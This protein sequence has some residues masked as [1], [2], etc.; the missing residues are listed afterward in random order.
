VVANVANAPPEEPAA[1]AHGFLSHADDLKLEV[2]GIFALLTYSGIRDWKWGTAYWR[3]NPEGWFGMDT[4]S[5][6]KDKL[7]HAYS[8]YVMTELF[9]LRL[10]NKYGKAAPVTVYP[11]IFSWILMLYVEFFDGFSVDHG[12]SYEDLVMDTVGVSASFFR[13]TFPSVGRVVDYRLEYFPSETM[14]GFHPM[15]DY[16]GQKFL[17]AFRPGGLDFLH[18]TPARFIELYV[19]Y[20]TRGFKNPA[21]NHPKLQRLYVGIGMDLAGVLS[22]AHRRPEE[23][24]GDWFDVASSAL[25]VFQLPYHYPAKTVYERRAAE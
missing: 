19:G 14:Q 12:F 20:Y 17:L 23:N 5:G 9:Y 7:G 13:N 3:F 15:I 6:G 25:G 21:P 22:R 1:P 4:G 16:M 10:R 24:P 2:G 18:Y 11:P 8:S